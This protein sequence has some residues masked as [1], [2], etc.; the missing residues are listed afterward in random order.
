MMQWGQFV[1]H[2]LART[3][4]LPNSA[5]TCG[6]NSPNCFNIQT[7]FQDARF[8]SNRCLPM[9]RS[10]PTCAGGR[11]EQFN[12]NTA[13]IDASLIYGSSSADSD[14]LRNG[15]SAF[16]QTSN[17]GGRQ[18]PP[19][20]ANGNFQAG[21]I[22]AN[23]FLGLAAFHTLFVRE[24]NRIAGM[25]QR[26]NPGW[27]ANRVFQESRKIVGAE[28]QSITFNEFLP[29]LIGSE[30]T[31]RIGSYGGYNQNIDPTI[32]NGFTTG[33]YRGGH[34]LVQ[35]FYQRLDN[36]FQQV[37][38]GGYTFEEGIFQPRKLPETG[39]DPVIRGLMAMNAKMPQRITTVLTERMFGNSD[40][41]STN[42]N[43]GRDHGLPSYNT[44]R[45]FC[46]MPRA[47]S[48][49]E[50]NEIPQG[51][52]NSLAT[53]YSHPD[54]IDLYVGGTLESPVTGGLMGT[55]YSC[56]VGEQFSRTRNGDRFWYEN[57]GIFTP[58]Q[59]AGLKRVTLSSVVCANG[60]GFGTA[61]IDAFTT[62]SPANSVPCQQIPQ[63]DLNVW[64]D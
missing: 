49:Q 50:L 27:D 44:W 48:F 20:D 30:F 28:I 3:T 32:S 45:T 47:N 1:S 40:L 21:D 34:G 12:E 58:A 10:T 52:R 39:I 63:L 9:A 41:A 46:G 29:K 24:H 13:F 61:P 36:N 55:T 6:T 25:L 15:R 43:R 17:I 64:R 53:L 19:V 22:R 38:Q 11:R 56:M 60:D 54:Q 35:E 37:P 57:P 31:K 14:K 33:A 62:A 16:L 8:G 4:Q 42:I 23:L 5:C 26:I 2:D 59:V 18:Y 7:V 51:V